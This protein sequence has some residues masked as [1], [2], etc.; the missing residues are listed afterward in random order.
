VRE[1]AAAGRTL[2]DG[3]LYAIGRLAMVAPAG[4]A[5]RVDPALKG[6]GEAL[7]AGA[8]RR[9]AI[10]NPAHAP[11]GRH[12]EEALRAAGLWAAIEPRLVRGENVSQ[13]LQFATTGGADGGLVSRSQLAAPGLP[14]LRSAV[15]DARLHRPIRQ[16]LVLIKGAG[17]TARRF[18]AWLAGPTAAT[19]F[20]AHGFDPP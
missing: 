9:F 17:D 13:A 5:L 6:L 15:V 7:R 18:E 10:A 3:R 12:A 4:S 11:Y 8:V 16:R 19:I 2:G 14:P 20:R 1:L